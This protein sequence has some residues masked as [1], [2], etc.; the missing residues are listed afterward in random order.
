MWKVGVLTKLVSCTG[1]GLYNLQLLLLLHIFYIKIS[2]CAC[3]RH[4]VRVCVYVCTIRYV[5]VGN[6]FGGLWLYGAKHGNG[7]DFG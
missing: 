5:G 2:P 4:C 7:C 6:G 3:A 1:I